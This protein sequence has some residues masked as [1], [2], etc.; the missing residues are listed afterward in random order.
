MEN[1]IVPNYIHRQMH[2]IFLM[3]FAKCP[4][5]YW[6]I[7]RVSSGSTLSHYYLLLFVI[8]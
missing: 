8:F 7:C 5:F 3:V 6:Q 4:E 2:L 1:N